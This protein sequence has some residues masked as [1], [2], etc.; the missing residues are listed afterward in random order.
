MAPRR[1]TFTCLFAAVRRRLAD[2]SGFTII[3]V[4]V[5]AIV[6]VLAAVGTL[7]AFD[8]ATASSGRNKSRTVA[9]GLAHRST[10]NVTGKTNSKAVVASFRRTGF[11]D[12]LYFT[13]LENTDPTYLTL[14]YGGVATRATDGSGIPTGGDDINEWAGEKCEHHWWGTQAQGEGRSEMPKWHGQ[15]LSNGTWTPTNGF[16]LTTAFVCGEITFASDDQVNGPF[17][18]NDDIL[19]SGTPDFGRTGNKDRVEV[20][21]I[22]A[23]DQ[24]WRGSGTPNFRTASG[25]LTNQ[26]RRLD[27]PPS[28]SA[29]KAQAADA[30]LYTGPTTLILN[31][32]TMNVTTEGATTNNVPLP[33][34]GVIHV[35]NTACTY[36]Y[37][38][39]DTKAVDPGCGL[40]KVSGTYSKDLTISAEDDIVVMDD[41]TR[42]TATNAVLGL[43]A[44]NFIRVWHPVTGC[45][46][47]AGTPTN[48]KID[49][50]ILSL[51]HSFTVDNYNCGASL[52]TLTVNG[53]IAQK[54]RGIVGTG[55]GTGY[56]KSYNYDDRLKYRSPPY[57]LDP[58]QASW[59]VLR[60]NDQ[61]G[62]R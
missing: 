56:I 60:Q 49:A 6:V 52:G 59:R 45:S 9:S 4:L 57:F 26:A 44:K 51:A 28:N 24:G 10:G 23:S 11:L 1:L 12:F 35:Q 55:G 14:S 30:Y 2:E 46:N 50:A 15:Y 16:D 8:A 58:V 37:K 13:D 47:D 42:T 19:I 41:L 33:A 29:I 62:A 21:N 32:T 54:H 40:V 20:A 27:L 43:V 18:S 17:H 48:V 53:A 34:N 39:G 3:E 36:G 31:G 61:S 7:A 22:S 5:S 38:P 25:S